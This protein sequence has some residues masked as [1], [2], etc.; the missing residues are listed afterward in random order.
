MINQIEDF[1]KLKEIVNDRK[2]SSISND[3]IKTWFNNLSGKIDLLNRRYRVFLIGSI[4]RY[5]IFILFIISLNGFTE[6]LFSVII[7]I[8]IMGIFILVYLYL[9]EYYDFLSDVTEKEK[10]YIRKEL[11]SI[12]YTQEELSQEALKRNLFG[13]YKKEYQKNIIHNQKI[14]NK[15]LKDNL[16]SHF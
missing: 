13:L 11:I 14:L 9:S 6:S 4:N 8:C 10:K 5:L 7:Y 1:K 15:L 12:L 3:D 2:V 16:P